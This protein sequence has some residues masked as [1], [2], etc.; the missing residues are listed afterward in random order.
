MTSAHADDS[1]VTAGMRV[2]TADGV[3]L[4]EV[5]EVTDT[6]FKVNAFYQPDYWLDLSLVASVHG[7]LVTLAIPR[8]DLAAYRHDDPDGATAG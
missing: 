8:E 5:K 3:D 4:G 6:Q 1:A 2:S 7:A